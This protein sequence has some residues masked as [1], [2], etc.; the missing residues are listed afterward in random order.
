M[1][2]EKP[3]EAKDFLAIKT[4]GL[5]K[6]YGSIQALLSVTISVAR[7]DIYA[8]IGPNG[9]G[10]STLFKI[11]STIL[12]P[13]LG[14]AFINGVSVRQGDDVRALIGYMPDVFG[15]YEDMTVAQYLDFF[16]AAFFIPRHQR[17]R[18]LKDIL[19]LTDLTGKRDAMVQSLSRGM[20]QRLGVARVLIH[21]PEVLILDEPASG[22]DPRARI[23]LRELLK[24]LAGMGKTILISSHILSE[25]SEVCNRIGIL[26]KGCLIYEG[27]HQEL[28]DRMIAYARIFVDTVDEDRERAM[29]LLRDAEFIEQVTAS[30]EGLEVR[31]KEN[32]TELHRILR[33]LIDQGCRLL[34]F[35]RERVSLETAFMALT[36]GEVA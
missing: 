10:K 21:D 35:Q 22:L 32:F 20:Q 30:T 2:D 11:L 28:S 12:K 6:R 4:D 8:L 29:T 3:H 9:A 31:V 7:G 14:S 18:L 33:L 34:R 23:E 19:E 26:E 25:L 1:N 15:V 13:D 17:A 24:E 16:A 36:S 5:C 27:S